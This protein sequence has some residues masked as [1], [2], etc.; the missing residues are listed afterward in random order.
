MRITIYFSF[1]WALVYSIHP[2][3]P[4]I[5]K[6]AAAKLYHYPDKFSWCPNTVTLNTC[7]HVKKKVLFWGNEGMQLWYVGRKRCAGCDFWIK[8]CF[9]ECAWEKINMTKFRGRSK[10]QTKVTRKNPTLWQCNVMQSE[11]V[12]THKKQTVLT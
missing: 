6:D 2:T 1:L 5:F 10:W 7:L 4:S 9:R 12:L 3:I 8:T 11:I